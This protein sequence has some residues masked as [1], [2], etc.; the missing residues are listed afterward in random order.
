MS[1]EISVRFRSLRSSAPF[2]SLRYHDERRESLAM[3]QDTIEPP[4]LSFDRGAMLTAVVDGGYG[5]C[6]TSD[7]SIGGLQAALD[8]A[9]R[10]AAATRGKSVVRYEPSQMDA[11][12]G[13]YQSAALAEPPSRSAIHDM[14]AA[15]CTGAKVDDRIVERFAAVGLYDQERA[16][17]TNTGGE[18]R[19]RFRFTV[20]YMRITANEGTVTQARSL[21]YE[22]QG[23]FELVERSHFAGSGARLAEEALLLIAAPNCPSEKMDLLLMPDQMMLQ[24]HESVGHPLELDRILGDERNFAGTSFV[25]PDMFGTYRYGSE[26]LN[27][28]FDPTRP[29]ELASYAFDDEGTRAEKTYLIRDGILERPLGGSISQTRAGLPGVAN[30][31]A[32]SWNRPPSDRMGNLNLEPGRASFDDLVAGIEHGVLLQTNS[33]WSI[34]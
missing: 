21:D 18:V 3:R 12:R 7:L 27:V 20:P 28:T 32:D 16:Y 19:Q 33:S 30:A 6:A 22:Q 31:R 34:D 8:R 14:L 29:E 1:S 26:H 5:Y 17:F 10:W 11:P 15:E 23:G 13:E 2:W 9:T 24:G 4:S 25:T